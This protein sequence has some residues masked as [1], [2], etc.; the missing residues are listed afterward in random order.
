[1]TASNLEN[2][3]WAKV[4]STACYIMKICVSRSILEKTPMNYSK[5]E[6]LISLN[7]DISLQL[8][9]TLQWKR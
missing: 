3:F 8:F 2:I 9:Y 5:V 6:R 7:L 1:M 4:M